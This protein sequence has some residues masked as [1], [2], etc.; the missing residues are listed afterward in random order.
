MVT[1]VRIGTVYQSQ[2][3]LLKL[4]F[5]LNKLGV[6]YLSLHS[7]YAICKKDLEVR[8]LRIKVFLVLKEWERGG[9]IHT[10]KVRQKKKSSFSV[11]RRR[12]N[13]NADFSAELLPVT[14]GDVK[15]TLHKDRFKQGRY[16]GF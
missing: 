3:I 13:E 8:D 12:R 5:F 16:H 14:C 1:G 4:V 10:Y 7:Q 2:K 9:S 15:G 6:K 11:P